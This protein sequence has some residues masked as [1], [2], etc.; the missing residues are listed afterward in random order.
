[1][2][3]VSI[4]RTRHKMVVAEHRALAERGAELVELRLDWLSRQPD[5]TRLLKERPTPVIA[6]CRR[7]IDRGR[8]RGSEPQ[9]QTLLREAIVA[10]VEY[11]DLEGDI[12]GQIPRY[13]KT[14]RIVSHHDFD[15]TPRNLEAIH[16]R[17]ADKDADI[18]KLVTMAN[19]PGDGVR[20]LELVAEAEV[21]TIGFCMGELGI[22][23]RILCG[24]YGAPF[25]Y[26]TFTRER[27]LAPGQLTFD[28]MRTLYRYD[29]IT[30]DTQLFGVLGDPI[31]HSLSPLVHNAAFSHEKL[32][33]V[34]VPIRVPPDALAAT[35]DEFGR[36]GFRGY[37]VTIPHKEAVL[38]RFGRPDDPAWEIGAAN[39]LYL[40]GEGEWQVMNTDYEAALDS[41]RLGL[42]PDDEGELEGKK[43]LVLGAGGAARAVV[44]GLV[45]NGVQVTIA[46]R[47]G[48]RAAKLAEQFRC[49]Q[50]QWENRTTVHADILVNCT[51]L[52]MHPNVD[53][54]PFDKNAFLEDMLVFDMVYNPE[55][56]L[57]LKEARERGCRTVS[58]IEMFV[59]QG[60]VQFERFTARDAPLDA[61]R[62]AL[63]KGISPVRDGS[64]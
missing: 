23:S 10:G 51:P 48:E 34:Y 25:T 33:A 6:T 38:E 29:S 26:A 56:T 21:P 13:G 39:T 53:D 2:I 16:A 9:R 1:M 15:E 40:D 47:R 42:D 43:A 8:W 18:V 19:S 60:A 30:K 64:S 58:G 20:M 12:A 57:L 36:L 22:P 45:R 27:V 32:D 4:G 11:V 54:T 63:R 3:A 49:K 5:L 7:Q 62:A 50:V 28:E 61:M 24:R 46:N 44:L 55:S 52:G 35:L 17:L 59:R 41:I 14:K 37:S 31:G